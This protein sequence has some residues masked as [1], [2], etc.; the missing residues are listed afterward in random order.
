MLRKDR[1]PNLDL[2]VA[3]LW[4]WPIKDDQATMEHPFFSLAKTPDTT[5]RRYEHNGN[6]LTIIPNVHGLPTVWDKDIL[7]FCCSQLVEGVKTCRLPHPT[8]QFEVYD[9]LVSTNR[10]TG[11]PGYTLLKRALDRL[12]GVSIQ[13]NIKTAGKETTHSFHL[14]EAWWMVEDAANATVQVTLADWLYR[15]VLSH[16][17][18]TL[19]K[20]YFRLDGGL[21][22][23]V[24]ELCRKH[25]GQQETW[26]IH[27]PLLYKKSGSIAPLR[28]FRYAIK[29]LAIADALPEY[30]LT[31]DPQAEKLTVY[32]RTHKGGLRQL[33][34]TLGLTT[35]THH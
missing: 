15:A 21:E 14:I 31:F 32:P 7:I 12:H 24:Y 35:S 18:L 16:E 9:F 5:I 28:R 1:Y 23:R 27:L 4:V 6:T 20:D 11:Q 17:V 26:A 25:C 30:R 19:H 22:R 2:F 13:T 29:Q 10:T 34:D 3:N 33:K 8:V